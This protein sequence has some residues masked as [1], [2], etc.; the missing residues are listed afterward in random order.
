M[1]HGELVRDILVALSLGSRCRVW[2]NNTGAIQIESRFIKFGLVGSAD[3]L[4]LVRGG[5]FLAVEVKIGNDQQ[6]PEQKNFE[7]MIHRFGGIYILARSVKDATDGLT[8][9]LAVKRI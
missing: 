7:R 6:S 5:I 4:G 9:A 1:T 8:C 2:Q 3:I